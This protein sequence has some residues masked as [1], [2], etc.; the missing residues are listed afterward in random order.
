[1]EYLNN[2]IAL[3]QENFL[4]NEELLKL[5]VCLRFKQASEVRNFHFNIQT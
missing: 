3:L 5:V 4:A 2:L 1:M